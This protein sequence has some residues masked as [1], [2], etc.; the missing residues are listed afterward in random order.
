MKHYIRPTM[1][2]G[3]LV[4]RLNRSFSTSKAAK[5]ALKN[6]LRETNKERKVA[7]QDPLR[8]SDFKIVEVKAHPFVR[9]KR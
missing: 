7:G 6:W 9:T 8:E 5:D 3:R 1:R 4:A 2:T